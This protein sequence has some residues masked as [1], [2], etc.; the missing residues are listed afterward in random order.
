MK[1][2]AKFAILSDAGDLQSALNILPRLL[3]F[4]VPKPNKKSSNRFSLCSSLDEYFLLH[5]P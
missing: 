3:K 1:S 4:G 2:D 5:L